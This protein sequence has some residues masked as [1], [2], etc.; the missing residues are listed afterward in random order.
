M[1]SRFIIVLFILFVMILGIN[2]AYSQE[3]TFGEAL[4]KVWDKQTPEQK[5]QMLEPVKEIAKQAVVKTAE[6]GWEVTKKL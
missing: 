5:E 1:N 3:M 2:H 4:K 6:V